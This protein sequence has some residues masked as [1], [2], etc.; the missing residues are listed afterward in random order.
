MKYNIDHISFPQDF[1]YI[2][3][4]KRGK[5]QHQSFDSFSLKHPPMDLSK[6]AKIFS[7]FDAL[8][9]FSDSIAAKD[10]IYVDRKIPNDEETK[11]L[12]IKLNMLYNLTQNSRMAKENN[13]QAEITYFV[14]CLNKDNEA[15]MRK[16][17][18]HTKTGTVLKVDSEIHKIIK[19]DDS[20]IP[21]S[22]IIRIECNRIDDIV[23]FQS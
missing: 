14:P 13:V 6:R 23:L 21:I 22:D 1:K 12:N 19:L 18:Y 3:V 17:Q 9:G 15:Y 16:G 8:K 20:E 5:P 4:I 11:D 2:E 7:P 10:I